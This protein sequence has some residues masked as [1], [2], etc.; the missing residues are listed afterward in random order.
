MTDLEDKNTRTYLKIKVHRIFRIDLART[1]LQISLSPSG[2]GQG[3]GIKLLNMKEFFSLP[4]SC[5]S[6]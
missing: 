6:P 1:L 2:E 4:S 3:E 5:P